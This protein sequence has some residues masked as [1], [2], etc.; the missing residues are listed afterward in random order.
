MSDE[1]TSV[2]MLNPSHP[3]E[4]LR[5][6]IDACGWSVSEASRKLNVD[7]RTLSRILNG[8]SGI[9]ASLA[10]TLEELGWSNA[11]FWMRLQTNWELA[12]ARLQK[13]AV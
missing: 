7:R 11:D 5:E 6:D 10:L 8:N 9:T 1:N 12:Q 2:R 4:I 13:H 3:G